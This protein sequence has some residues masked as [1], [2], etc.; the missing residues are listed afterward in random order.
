MMEMGFKFCDWKSIGVLVGKLEY[1]MLEIIWFWY[2]VFFN[3][4]FLVKFRYKSV[5]V[6]FNKFRSFC[7]SIKRRYYSVCCVDLYLV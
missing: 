4:Y 1:C 3:N 6:F 7:V 5:R 2:L